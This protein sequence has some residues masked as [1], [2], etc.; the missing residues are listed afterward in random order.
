MDSPILGV[1]FLSQVYLFADYQ[2]REFSTGLADH[3]EAYLVGREEIQCV[4]HASEVGD[5]GWALTATSSAA[6]STA[7]GTGAKS[8]GLR[9]GADGMSV[10]CCLVALVGLWA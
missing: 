6:A 9:R 4:E 1:P 2:T 7:T 5:M 3:S 8:S 10:V